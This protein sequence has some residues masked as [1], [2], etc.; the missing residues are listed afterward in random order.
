MEKLEMLSKIQ[1]L[2]AIAL[3]RLG[4]NE[5]ERAVRRGH[6]MVNIDRNAESGVWTPVNLD[7]E[8]VKAADEF[9]SSEARSANLVAAT[10]VAQRV[11]H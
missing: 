7:A 11:E 8:I 9:A 5:R 3:A 10:S 2:A 4:A 6:L 1:R